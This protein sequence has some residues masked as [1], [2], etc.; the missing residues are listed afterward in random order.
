MS[1]CLRGFQLR[2]VSTA[3]NSSCNLDI[4]LFI[5]SPQTPL[6]SSPSFFTKNPVSVL[7]IIYTVTAGRQT[8]IS[9][10]KRAQG[11]MAGN[12]VS[13]PQQGLIR[14]EQ[15]QVVVDVLVLKG[16][17]LKKKTQG[18]LGDLCKKINCSK[19]QVCFFSRALRIASGH[20]VGMGLGLHSYSD[21]GQG[22]EDHPSS[23]LNTYLTG[24]QGGAAT[25]GKEEAGFSNP[26]SPLG[27][28]YCSTADPGG[29]AFMPGDL[30]LSQVSY[31]NK[32]ISCL[33]LCLLLNSFFKET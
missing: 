4:H 7:Y 23:D 33:P 24:Y 22:F 31:P 27:D 16:P 32:S 11:Q 17:Y 3:L 28:K 30:H 20:W 26:H 10:E 5:H 1:V 8:V 2:D 15:T 12:H 18:T 6:N 25:S 13:C 21:Q 29:R 9:R 14:M 19:R